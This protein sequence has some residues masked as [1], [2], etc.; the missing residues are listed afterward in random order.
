M[1]I[2]QFAVSLGIRWSEY[3]Q[4]RPQKG[5]VDWAWR[6]HRRRREWQE[7]SLPRWVFEYLQSGRL[8][9]YCGLAYRVYPSEQAAWDALAAALAQ[10]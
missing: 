10:E 4:L 9:P 6:N 3:F 1:T 8:V 5:A 7:Y 2:E